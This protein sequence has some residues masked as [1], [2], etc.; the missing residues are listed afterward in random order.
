MEVSNED[1]RTTLID[2]AAESGAKKVGESAVDRALNALVDFVIDKYGKA[3]VII[4]TVFQLYLKNAKE[5]YNQVRT[6]ATG[7][8]PRKI[9]GP[10]NIYVNVGLQYGEKEI[11]TFTVEP[12]LDIS[13]NILISGT[14]GIGKS[15]LMRY[16]FLNTADLGEYVPVLVELRRISKQPS[17]Q[18]SILELIYTCM[19]GFNVQLPREQFEYSLQLGKYI[20]LFDGLD[21]VKTSLSA[22]TAEALQAFS[23]KYPKNPCIVTSRPMQEISPLET[24]TIM[25]PKPLNKKQAILLA[26]KI[27]ID[28]DK[29]QEFCHQLDDILYDK[30]KDFA[31]NPLLLSMMFLTFMRNSSI[32]DHLADFYKNAYDALYS[33]HDSHDKG[34][35]HRD[36]QCKTLDEDDFKR[37]FSHFCFHSYMKEIYEFSKSTILF[38]LGKSIEKLKLDDIKPSD[39]LADLRNAVCMIIKDGDTY[40]FSHRSFQ[41]YFAAYYTSCTLTD[42]Q[43]KQLFNSILSNLAFLGKEDYSTLLSQIEPERFAVNALEEGLRTLQTNATN[44]LDPDIYIFKRWC[45]GIDFSGPNKKHIGFQIGRDMYT[46]NMIDLFTTYV[47][48]PTFDITSYSNNLR[49][50]MNYLKKFKLY[51]PEITEL[52]F[53]TIDNSE[54]LT[55]SER[56]AI[57][58][59]ILK[60]CGKGEIYVLISEWLE[61]ID[62]KRALLKS[63]NFI[64]E[65]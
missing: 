21:E 11:D 38:L 37:V 23:A 9:I 59:A 26:S 20:F 25:E 28:D 54:L 6:L 16:L 39:Y 46:F 17:G 43:Q 47:K 42:E 56:N 12:M 51:G 55:E 41:A 18:L 5:R 22:E 35:Y 4:G 44:A 50:V 32:P 53:D 2:T 27:R 13:K 1:S 48:S 30:H 36:F 52:E 60:C 65:L 24:F 29:A 45:Y 40:R 61:E 63:P 57:Y 15:M 49:T 33:I 3:K 10:D 8:T 64:D 58:S 7:H 31:E 34:S 19:Q 62:D 14:G